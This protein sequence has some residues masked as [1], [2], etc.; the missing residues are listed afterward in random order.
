MIV[1]FF[2]GFAVAVNEDGFFHFGDGIVE[3]ELHPRTRSHLFQD[4]DLYVRV[5]ILDLETN[6]ADRRELGPLSILTLLITCN[7]YLICC[8]SLRGLPIPNS[9]TSEQFHYQIPVRI[10]AQH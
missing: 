5:L 6:A 8:I 2:S 7:P 4:V 3:K 1:D 9:S 10:S